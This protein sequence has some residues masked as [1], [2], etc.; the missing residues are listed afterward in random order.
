M[1]VVNIDDHKIKY[2][3]VLKNDDRLQDFTKTM[4]HQL[5]VDCTPNGVR[6]LKEKYGLEV[7]EF[8]DNE[9]FE[10]MI[11]D[12]IKQFETDPEPENLHMNRSLVLGMNEIRIYFYNRLKESE[13]KEKKDNIKIILFL[14]I[15]TFVIGVGTFTIIKWTIDLFSKIF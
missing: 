12:I 6:K 4:M 11:N 2:H 3:G 1:A 15:L 14:S 8:F 9:L 5:D 7:T 13:K 10:V